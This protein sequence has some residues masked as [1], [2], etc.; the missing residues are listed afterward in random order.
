MEEDVGLI[1]IHHR[2]RLYELNP[3]DSELRWEVDPWG[4]WVRPS[5]ALAWTAA[6]GLCFAEAA[7]CLL[8]LAEQ[9]GPGDAGGRRA[10]AP[11]L[12]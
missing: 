6:K 10:A 4:R 3:R 7:L 1:G 11:L 5:T 2:G 9:R 8:G 12:G